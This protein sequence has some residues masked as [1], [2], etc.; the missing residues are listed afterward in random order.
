[1]KNKFV[2]L[3]TSEAVLEKIFEKLNALK[4]ININSLQKD[5]TVLIIIDMVNGFTKKGP[6]QSPRIASIIPDIIK[7]SYKCEELKIKKIVFADS[8]TESSPEFKSY[9]CHCL[10]G[11]NES[12]V[13]R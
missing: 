8:H 6:L 4:S 13:I 7:L 11:T 5:K 3:K 9:P 1:M 10:K 2:F 12:K